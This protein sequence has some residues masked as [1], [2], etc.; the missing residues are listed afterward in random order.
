MLYT[1]VFAGRDTHALAAKDA[2]TA[3][4]A[5]AIAEALQSQR[6]EIKYIKS[7]QEGEFG[8]EMLRLLAKEEAEELP[9]APARFSPT[10]VEIRLTE[11]RS[12]P[13]CRASGPA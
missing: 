12:F 3:R 11:G 1:I 8:L 13:K 2:T 5:L 7:P 10:R 4:E 9:I 6:G